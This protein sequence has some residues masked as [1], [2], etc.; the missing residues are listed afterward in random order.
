MEKS[1]VKLKFLEF[2]PTAETSKT[3]HVTKTLGNYGLKIGQDLLHKLGV[4][5]SFSSKKYDL[6][7]CNH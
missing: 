1:Q 7:Q 3:V 4:D 2:N 5:I 6:E